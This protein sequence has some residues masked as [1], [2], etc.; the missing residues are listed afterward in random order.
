MHVL[1]VGGGGQLGQ[2]L[3]A[4]YRKQANTHL[5]VW[6]RAD[7]DISTP[8][9]S[10]QVADLRPDTVINAAAWTDVDGAEAL[11]DAA[12]AANA[13]GPM[14]LA[15]G[16]ARCGARL[17][18][19]STNEVFAGRPGRFYR[20][21][22][23]PYPG[24]VYAR[25]KLA[26]ESA[27]RSMLDNLIIARV[28]WLFGR[29]GNSFPM[30]ITAAADKYGALRVVDDEFGNPTYAVDA[31]DAMIQ[32]IQQEQR[33][34]FHLVN[35][36]YASRYEFARAVLQRNGRSHVQLTPIPSSEWPRPAPPPP[37]AVL[38]NQTASAI[39]ISLRPWNEALDDFVNSDPFPNP[40]PTPG[41][42]N[43]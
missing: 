3:V 22:D 33:G 20:E 39:S 42:G 27:A 37:H 17:L 18:H 38:I 16:C 28:A 26:G 32:L 25:S 34:I 11:P 7:Y 36:G 13:L 40:Q 15:E 4:A 8:G 5:T 35:G 23:L 24:S 31:A 19:V 41:M 12:Y 21:Y 1:I 43:A 29:G 10:A 30:K 14:Y 9:I 2:A 6:N